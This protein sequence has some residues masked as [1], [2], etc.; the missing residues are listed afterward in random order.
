MLN[1][2]AIRTIAVCVF[3]LYLVGENQIVKRLLDKPFFFKFMRVFFTLMFATLLFFSCIGL[4]PILDC[5]R[6]LFETHELNISALSKLIPHLGVIVLSVFCW[7]YFWYYLRNDKDTILAGWYIKRYYGLN[8]RGKYGKSYR[9]LQKASE[10][11]P[12][13][14]QIWF[15]LANFVQLVLHNTEQADQ[16]LAKAQE[17]LDSKPIESPREIA[18]VEFYFGHISQCRGDHKTAVK[19][20][21][22]AYELDPTRYRKKIYK[23]ALA[24]A[25]AEST[26]AGQQ[27]E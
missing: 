20:M 13:A 24:L 12:D 8:K 9:C 17:I 15:L 16:Y 27:S 6:K 23:E 4:F 5:A 19:H 2:N 22:K 3:G 7:R 1:L 25:E 10:I 18:A 11:K 21:K 14:L 26:S